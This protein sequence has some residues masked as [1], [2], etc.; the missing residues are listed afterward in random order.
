MVDKPTERNVITGEVLAPGAHEASSEMKREQARLT[1]LIAKRRDD[2]NNQNIPADV[3]AR[4]L[5]QLEGALVSVAR[6]DFTTVA[7][8]LTATTQASVTA[9]VETVKADNYAAEL[10]YMAEMSESPMGY[11]YSPAAMRYMNNLYRDAVSNSPFLQALEQQLAAVT[12]V[13]RQ[14]AQQEQQNNWRISREMLEDPAFKPHHASIT[15]MRDMGL[16]NGPQAASILQNIR[17][18]AD[19]ASVAQSATALVSQHME[20][21][22]PIIINHIQHIPQA[23]QQHLR[24]QYAQE[25][26]QLDV[27]RMMHDWARVKPEQRE[28]AY[29]AMIAA[30]NDPSKLTP[31]QQRVIHLSQVMVAVDGAAAVRGTL[32]I[33]ARNE[34][35]AKYLSDPTI[36]REEREAKLAEAMKKA[37]VAPADRA[38][39]ERSIQEVVHTFD[40]MAAKG[41]KVGDKGYNA[42]FTAEYA[43]NMR[44]VAGIAT[45][46][47]V[48]RVDNAIDAANRSGTTYGYDASMR[49]IADSYA[50]RDTP[51]YIKKDETR[52]SQY[53]AG[54]Q[55]WQTIL[56]G[57]SKT[58]Q[59]RFNEANGV[60]TTAAAPTPQSVA[61]TVT[62]AT[63]TE[64]GE[65]ID[66]FMK[67]YKAHVEGTSVAG[68]VA[69]P[70][71]GIDLAKLGITGGITV[72]ENSTPTGGKGPQEQGASVVV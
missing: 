40:D 15:L 46:S 44:E 30:G 42:A 37:G 49:F 70:P 25:D 62:G 60:T 29:Q 16:M 52:A 59:A 34:E 7:N 55:Q 38:V 39:F 65:S 36:P 72:A 11:K 14:M 23:S 69:A 3:K 18:G 48:R 5:D 45:Q 35:L 19:V 4:L 47:D 9:R 8:V 20:A 33:I 53:N 2:I 22:R 13:E 28:A 27:R 63:V 26:G 31:E 6:G 17:D 24:Q 57:M 71:P 50:H 51:E 66:D 1:D 64:N 32:G 61:T 43:T 67:R 41:I 56:S 68:T 58:E 10:T 21:A 12:P 54:T